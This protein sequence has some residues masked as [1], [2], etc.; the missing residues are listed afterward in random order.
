MTK[1]TRVSLQV[2][3]S[4]SYSDA[5]TNGLTVRFCT[6]FFLQVAAACHHYGET[7]PS[8]TS[9]Q[10]DARIAARG[11]GG[12]TQNAIGD[13]SGGQANGRRRK[14]CARES[15]KEEGVT[16]AKGGI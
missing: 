12:A 11:N 14:T 4:F 3:L 7:H 5:K 9:N 15:Q 10:G 16:A 2:N 1:L 13:P 6:S 8:E